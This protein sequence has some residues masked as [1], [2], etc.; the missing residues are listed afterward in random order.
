MAYR[1]ILLPLELSKDHGAVFDEAVRLVEPGV[2]VVLL[3]HVI[4]SIAGLEEDELEDFYTPLRERAASLLAEWSAELAARGLTVQHAILMG[5]RGP[6]VVRHAIEEQCDLI[7]VASR[8]PD[9]E[10]TGWGLGTTSHQVALMAP[11]SV[12]LVR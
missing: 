2:G 1:R 4:E 5:K 3:L 9:P 7:V 8:A 10:R 6:T 12:L 11:C